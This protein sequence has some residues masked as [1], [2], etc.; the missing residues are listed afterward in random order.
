MRVQTLLNYVTKHKGFVFDGI[1]LVQTLRGPALEALIRPHASSR[2]KCSVCGRPGA[3]YDV[4][5]AR[6]FEFIPAWG[7]LVF[8]VYAMRRVDCRRCGVRV[9]Q[10][11]WAQGKSRLCTRYMWFLADWA[12]LLSWSETARVFRTSWDQ[13]F[14]SVEHAVAWGRQHMNME[15]ITAVGIDEMAWGR[16][17]RYVTVVYQLN[18][19]A[20]RLLHVAEGRSVRS[21]LEF[22]RWL[23]QE[24]CALLEVVCSDMWQPYLRVIAKKASQ[25]LHVLDRFHI[26]MHFNKAIDKVRAGEAR[27]MKRRGENPVLTGSRWC[28]LKRLENL[29]GRQID[30]LCDLL[31]LN[32]KTVSA[33]LMREDFQRFWQYSSPHWAGVFL[34][35]WCK[36]AMHSRIEP[37]KQCARMLR[38]HRP[39]VLNWFKARKQF[40]SGIVEGMNGKAKLV[41]RKAYGFSSFEMLQTALYHTLGDLPKPKFTHEF[42]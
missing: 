22:F 30:K 17:H 32:L 37:M 20:R 34:D 8:F 12:R 5:S 15:G 13:V 2:A 11:P 36:R 39:L 7:L 33:Y 27:E 9:E 23:G 10:V 41:T 21:A 18:Q 42:F 31:R 3:T 1:D 4:Q 40:S 29:S 24:R 19:G 25:A 35:Q 16:G 26:M 14:R 6:R 38:R 28:L